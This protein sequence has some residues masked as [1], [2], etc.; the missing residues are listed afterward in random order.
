MGTLR[1]F[2]DA[3]P[4]AVLEEHLRRREVDADDIKARIT[5]SAQSF[6]EWMFS[7]RALVKRG[8]ARIGDT[9]G[10]PGSSLAIQLEGPNAGL[11]HDHSTGEGG[12]L[13]GLFQ[14]YMGYD[15]NRNFVLAV[16]EIAA[17]FLRDPV[18]VRRGP[19]QQTVEQRITEKKAKLGTKPRADMVELGAPVATW[20]YVDLRGNQ[21]ASVVRFEPDGTPDSKT[22]RPFCRREVNGRWSWLPGVPDLR[23][24][25][26][27]PGIATAS[28]VILCE[29]EKTAQALIDCGI[30]A[31]TAMQGAEAPIEKTDWSPLNGKTVIVWPDND[32]PGFK[33]GTAVA[34]RLVAL[35][36]TVR[37]VPVPQ[38]A[39]L[40]WDAADAVSE[41]R[42]VRALIDAAVAHTKAE[43]PRIRI[44]DIDELE[45]LPPPDWLI[46]QLVPRGGLC[47]LWGRSGD[48]KSWLA[49][50]LCMRVATGTPW[51]GREAKQGLVLYV[52][53][54][55]AFGFGSRVRAWRRFRGEGLQKPQFKLIPHSVAITSEDLEHLTNAILALASQEAMP[56]LIVLDTLARTFGVG[57]ENK[58][59]DMNAYVAAA[60]KLRDATGAT[61]LIV[62][63]SGVGDGQR[64][65]GSSVLRGAADAML[66]V[67]RDGDK[68]TVI[69][70][71]PEGKQKDA[72]EA[73]DICLRVQK[74]AYE[75]AGAEH[76]TLLLM[77][78]DDPLPAIE[79]GEQ[80]I[81]EPKFGKVEQ[82]VLDALER[83]KEPL[84]LNRILAMS[85]QK[86]NSVVIALRSLV[87]KQAVERAQDGPD[88]S[89]WSVA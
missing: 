89:V 3:L 51:F 72:E 49:N 78:D 39:P 37:V 12:D 4:L 14:A 54:E 17:E 29:G 61:V 63:H 55:G 10:S 22:Y 83:A 25:Y 45:D 20:R 1:D 64:E 77:E 88:A 56:S 13:I 33:Y 31:T 76:T 11:W 48:M 2:N 34:A 74:V 38:D 50:D 71:S 79:P 6:V 75:H 23:P 27:L 9:S 8:E 82:A 62:H 28:T 87:E 60:D 57:D 15:G 24:L 7:G 84:G 69:N 5:A 86:K 41:G 81:A 40:K 32:A 21:I 68:L 47:V 59:A 67:T 73:E 16:K 58:Q 53:A 18:E 46:D 44:L 42:D 52:A 26:N 65:R 80:A 66:K 35:G 19:T 70:R 43:K 36:C 85:G 30:A